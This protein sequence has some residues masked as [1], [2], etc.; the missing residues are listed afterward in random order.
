MEG[1][2]LVGPVGCVRL[3]YDL[4]NGLDERVGVKVVVAKQLVLFVPGVGAG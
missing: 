2:I 4:M 3:G 1:R